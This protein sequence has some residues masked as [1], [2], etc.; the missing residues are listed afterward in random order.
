MKS[1]LVAWPRAVRAFFAR[2]FR[3]LSSFFAGRPAL[4]RAWLVFALYG[5]LALP[6]VLLGTLLPAVAWALFLAALFWGMGAERASLEWDAV[7]TLPSP[8][9]FAFWRWHALER[10]RFLSALAALV[11]GLFL[12]VAGRLI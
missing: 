10:K 12:S 11:T 3:T 4:T 6:A 7:F 8:G 9:S 2:S 5:L 1:L